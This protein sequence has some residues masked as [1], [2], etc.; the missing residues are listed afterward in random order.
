MSDG[1]G[2]TCPNCGQ[3]QDLDHALYCQALQASA[4]IKDPVPQWIGIV[5]ATGGLVSIENDLHVSEFFQCHMK[6]Y[7]N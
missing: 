3:P 1:A 5:H 7:N 2:I 4:V 6:W